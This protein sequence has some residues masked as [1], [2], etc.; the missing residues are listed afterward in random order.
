MQQFIEPFLL[1]VVNVIYCVLKEQFIVL[2]TP[3]WSNRH[4]GERLMF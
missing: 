1:T 3:V 4:P 2:F